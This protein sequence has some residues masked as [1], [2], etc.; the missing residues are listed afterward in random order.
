[1]AIELRREPIDGSSGRRLITAL[2]D[3]ERARYG[4]QHFGCTVPREFSA[5]AGVF[6]VGYCE[7]HAVS[8]GGIRSRGDGVA[9][10]KRLYVEPTRRGLGLGRQI[11]RTLEEAAVSLGYREMWLETGIRQPEAIAL[12]VSAGYRPVPCDRIVAENPWIRCFAKQ[13]ARR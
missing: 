7:G 3:E 1:V 9:E 6:L 8:C 5:P 11:L 2:L 12:Y 4:A 13:L 10:L